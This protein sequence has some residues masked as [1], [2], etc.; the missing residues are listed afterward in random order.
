MTRLEEYDYEGAT[1]I[2]VVLLLMSFVLLLAI[3]QLQ[4]WSRR[5]QV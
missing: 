4:R 3:N 1:A 5:W 2:A